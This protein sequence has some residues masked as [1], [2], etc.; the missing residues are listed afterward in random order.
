M[1]IVLSFLPTRYTDD[2]RD[3]GRDIPNGIC[4]HP[5]ASWVGESAV[6]YSWISSAFY[7]TYVIAHQPYLAKGYRAATKGL[8]VVHLD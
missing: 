1:Y 3:W 6:F 8:V 2:V 7:R 4:I 5:V